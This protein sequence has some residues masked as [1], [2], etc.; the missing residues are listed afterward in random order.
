VGLNYLDHAKETNMAIP[1]EPIL[2]N[3]FSPSII[4]H[5]DKIVKPKETNELDYEV[6]LVIVIGKE[7]RRI[8]ESD[9]FNYIAGKFHLNFS[10]TIGYTVG[11]D[12]SARDWQLRKPGGQWMV[13]IIQ[14]KD[15]L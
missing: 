15:H 6:E 12:V 7:A 11:H 13:Y 3:K 14:I 2:F 1:S 8:K 9:A 4:G 5:L 10:N